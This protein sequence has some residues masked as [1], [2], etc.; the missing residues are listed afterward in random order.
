[1]A[2]P[3]QNLIFI[4]GGAKSGKSRFAINAASSICGK[5]AFI[6]TAEALD[7][8]MLM[9]IQRHKRERAEDWLTLEE[10]LNIGPLLKDVHLLYE[11]ILIDCLT[12][13]LSNL[14]LTSRNVEVDVQGFLESVTL[15][16]DH[17]PCTNPPKSRSLFIVSNEVGLGI[18]PDNALAR[19][20][21]DAA[22]ELH[23]RIAALA[24]EVYL[25]AA[26]IPLK[27]KGVVQST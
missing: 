2:S 1:M 20:F 6:A 19:R 9:R 25:V 14:L 16:K 17:P 8:E 3:K 4:T 27:I 21:R 12:L 23:Q 24:D 11:V 13:W 26:G 18:V 7:D 10:P 5:K 15:Y 22:G